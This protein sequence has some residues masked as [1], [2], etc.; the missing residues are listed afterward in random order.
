MKV[1]SGLE[2]K[3]HPIRLKVTTE[4]VMSDLVQSQSLGTT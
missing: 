4:T 1:R 2:T 3:P